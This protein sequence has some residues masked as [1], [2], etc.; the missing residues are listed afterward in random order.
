MPKSMWASEEQTE[1]TRRSFAADTH[2]T[3]VDSTVDA[4]LRQISARGEWTNAIV[5][6]RNK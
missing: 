4:K 3:G 1:Y 2:N 6:R 5:S